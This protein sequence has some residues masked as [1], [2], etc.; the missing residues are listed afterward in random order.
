MMDNKA[1]VSRY[2]D[3]EYNNVAVFLKRG[4]DTDIV[5]LQAHTTAQE[6]P[7]IHLLRVFTVKE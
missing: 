5:R 6:Q 7:Y 4:R 2:V 1:M 3:T